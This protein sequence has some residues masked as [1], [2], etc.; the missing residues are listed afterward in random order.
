M[1][2]RGGGVALDIIITTAL[3]VKIRTRIV[4]GYIL[5]NN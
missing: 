1:N 4:V 3:K 5:N 2:L